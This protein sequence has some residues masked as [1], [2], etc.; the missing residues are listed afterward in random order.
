MLDFATL[1]STHIHNKDVKTYA[2]AQFCGIDRAN[3]YKIIKGQRKPTSLEMV[4]NIC[5]FMRLSPT[6]QF[7]M[8][9]AYRI[10]LI[11]SENYYRRKAVLRFFEE[12]RLPI[13]RLPSTPPT[14][15]PNDTENI[16]LLNS[17]HEVNRSLFYTISSELKRQDGRIDLLIQPDSEFLMN[18]LATGDYDSSSVKIRHIICLNNTQTVTSS[19][20]NYNLNSLKQIIPLYSNHYQYDCYYYYDNVDSVTNAFSLFP[21][22]VITPKC[23]YLLTADM[24][25]GLTTTDSESLRFFSCLYEQYWRNSSPLL[26]PSNNL[27]VQLEY[28]QGTIQPPNHS[29]S[30][31][32]LPCLT[33]FLTIEFLEKYILK[34]L[35]ERKKLILSLQKYVEKLR[36]RD[37]YF[38]IHYICSLDGIRKFLEIGRVGEYPPQYCNPFSLRDRIYLIRQLMTAMRTKRYH[39]LKHNIGSI[40]NEFFLFVGQQKGYFMFPTAKQELICLN[41]EESDLLYTFFDF[42][43]SLDEEMFYT[44]EEAYTQLHNLLNEYSHSTA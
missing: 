5:K 28:A 17:Q 39:L 37:K 43:K 38:A 18:I 33:P 6:E 13:F 42:C 4:H 15:L 27:Y 35:P 40:D 9:E 8:E 16:I 7:E 29:Y 3:M 10:A 30:F 36:D 44:Y 32:M 2:L 31:Q 41:I 1:L 24:Q 12:F 14:E 25:S 11:G 23:V 21:Y 19:R 22:A 34:T 20:Q 26:H